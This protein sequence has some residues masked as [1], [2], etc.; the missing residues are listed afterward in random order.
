MINK[1]Y[2]GQT[3]MRDFS[4]L[5]KTASAGK[6][7][8][9]HIQTILSEWIEVQGWD[10]RDDWIGI[11]TWDNQITAIGYD[12]IVRVEAYLGKAPRASK[13]PVGFTPVEAEATQT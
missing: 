11:A 10:A 12:K 5:A 9:L 4:T 13:L 8:R 3:L 1:E 2:F 7:L 6:H